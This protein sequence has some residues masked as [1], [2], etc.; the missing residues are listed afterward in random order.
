MPKTNRSDKVLTY[1]LQL[2][3]SDGSPLN[4]WVLT[5]FL[6][7]EKTKGTLN[8]LKENDR[9]ELLDGICKQMAALERFDYGD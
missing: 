3:D 5:L 6:V 7:D 8:M 9:R 2:T 1:N 4:N